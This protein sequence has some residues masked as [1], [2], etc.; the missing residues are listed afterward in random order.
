MSNIIAL[1][2][3]YELLELTALYLSALDLLN[4][5]STCSELYTHIRKNEVIFERLKSVAICDGRGLK[6]R[7]EYQGLY[8][9]PQTYWDRKA[10]N[11]ILSFSNIWS[12]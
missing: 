4:L 5:A 11:V 7:Q 3:Q 9:V 6:L 1:A 2:S 12:Y 10:A 8:S